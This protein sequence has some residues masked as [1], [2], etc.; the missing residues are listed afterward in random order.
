M[1]SETRS[2]VVSATRELPPR[3]RET[4]DLDTPAR[5]ATSTI[6]ARPSITSTSL[7]VSLFTSPSLLVRSNFYRHPVSQPRH[8]N[9]ALLSGD[10]ERAKTATRSL[11]PRQPHPGPDLS[12]TIPQNILD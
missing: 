3:T 4:V 11:P 9:S 2:R 5:R 12:A 8:D 1:A 6:V 7:P 10:L